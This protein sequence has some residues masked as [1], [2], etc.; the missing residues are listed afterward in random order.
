[1]LW[2]L[3]GMGLIIYLAPIAGNVLPADSVASKAAPAMSFLEADVNWWVLTGGLTW[4]PRLKPSCLSEVVLSLYS[5][6]SLGQLQQ[7]QL[8]SR[9]AVEHQHKGELDAVGQFGGRFFS[10]VARRAEVPPR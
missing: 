7:R 6:T 2:Y 9:E 10:T 1:M 3:R 8:A 4:P 5:N